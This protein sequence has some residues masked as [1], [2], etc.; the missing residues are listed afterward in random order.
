MRRHIMEVRL[1]I[2]VLAHAFAV[3]LHAQVVLAL[4]LAAGDDDRFRS[5]I[6]AVFDELGDG[7]ERIALRQGNDRDRIP[8]I[9]DSQIPAVVC[10]SDLES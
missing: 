4:F 8:V 2:G 10:P 3:I 6:D 7:L 5:R 9:A 1:A